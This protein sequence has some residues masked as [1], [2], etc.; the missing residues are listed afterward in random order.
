MLTLAHDVFSSPTTTTTRLRRKTSPPLLQNQHAAPKR[1]ETALAHARRALKHLQLTPKRVPALLPAMRHHRHQLHA[2]MLAHTNTEP[3]LAQRLRDAARD[4]DRVLAALRAL[5]QMRV[6]Y[7]SSAFEAALSRHCAAPLDAPGLLQLVDEVQR[8]EM[9]HELEAAALWLGAAFRRMRRRLAA[10]RHDAHLGTGA[11]GPGGAVCDASP[12]NAPL[13]PAGSRAIACDGL[14]AL[15]QLPA[16]LLSATPRRAMSSPPS[17]SMVGTPRSRAS[18]DA[19]D[20][21][22]PSAPCGRGAIGVRQVPTQEVREASDDLGSCAVTTPFG[23]VE[24]D[25]AASSNVRGGE[26]GDSNGARTS[27]DSCASLAEGDRPELAAAFCSW[28]LQAVS[29]AISRQL[30]T[31]VDRPRGAVAAASVEKPPPPRIVGR[32]G[33]TPVPPTS[34]HTAVLTARSTR[35]R[36]RRAP[37]ATLRESALGA[38]PSA[39][40]SVP[41]EECVPWPSVATSSPSASVAPSRTRRLSVAADRRTELSKTLRA[42]APVEPRL[43]PGPAPDSSSRVSGELSSAPPEL[44]EE[45]AR[46]GARSPAPPADVRVEQTVANVVAQRRAR[47]SVAHGAAGHSAAARRR[48]VH[49][50]YARRGRAGSDGRCPNARPAHYYVAEHTLAAVRK[51][52]VQRSGFA[53]VYLAG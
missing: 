11:A 21:V 24:L 15:L 16:N 46:A 30:G 45:P 33:S 23:T 2:L 8:P 10:S 44:H 13:A 47:I 17:P 37:P 50:E 6:A 28:R 4:V 20:I 40:T 12:R 38:A 26:L 49:T 27:V 53:S 36:S 9:V 48:A 31:G 22:S 3:K 14:D 32:G 51:L 1:N 5:S 25:E 7:G 39:A 34:L 42:A 52:A 43:P 35:L 18:P 19:S 41:L 29:W